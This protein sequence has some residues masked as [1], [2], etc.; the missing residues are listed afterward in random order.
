MVRTFAIVNLT[1]DSFSDGGRFLGADAALAHARAMLAAGADVIDLGAESSHPDAAD[2][3]AAEQVRRLSPVLAALVAEGAAVSVDTWRPE[4][5]AAVLPL[6]VRW[7]NCVRGFRSAGALDAAAAAPPEVGFVVM[8]QRG[9]AARASRPAAEP[10]ALLAELHAFFGER[11]A[12]FAAH[13]IGRSRLVFDPGMGFFLGDTPAPSLHVL[14]Q[15]E[16]LRDLDAPLMISVSRK[17]VVAGPA[18]RPPA[19][20]GAGTLAAELWAAR[21]GVAWIRTHDVGAF[22]DAWAIEQ[23]IANAP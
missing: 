11:V 10:A 8:F 3:D 5:M 15:L 4:V 20:R 1:T 18:G 12:A 17:S 14:R 23:A 7:L 21:Q 13:G 9:T 6:G 22:R 19:A 16:A 2:V